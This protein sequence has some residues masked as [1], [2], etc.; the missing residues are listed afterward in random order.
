MDNILNFKFLLQRREQFYWVVKQSSLVELLA[1]H[2]AKG[3]R[4]AELG[5]YN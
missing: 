4:V 5:I 1:A 2:E 3:Q